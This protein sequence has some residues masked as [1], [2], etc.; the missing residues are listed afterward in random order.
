MQSEYSIAEARN[1]L[2]SIV[3]AAETGQSVKLTRRGKPVAVI[4]SEREFE[5]LNGQQKGFWDVFE[6]FR[7]ET[8][9][10]IGPELFDNLRDSS[11]G[12]NPSL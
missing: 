1:H 9:E 11:P 4:L 10:D 7:Q 6:T 5:R 8:S 3:R 12:R 2:S